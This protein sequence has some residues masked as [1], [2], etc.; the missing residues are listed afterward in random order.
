M[1]ASLNPCFSQHRLHSFDPFTVVVNREN[2][3]SVFRDQEVI[4]A[5]VQLPMDRVNFNAVTATYVDGEP[6]IAMAVWGKEAGV[7][8]RH[9]V[10]LGDEK[11]LPYKEDVW[12]VCINATGTNLFFGTKS[13]S[14]C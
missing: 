5:N 11:S 3:C 2:Q 8:L 10:T 7:Y 9:A 14:F 6:C 13:G 4:H 1:K 12:C